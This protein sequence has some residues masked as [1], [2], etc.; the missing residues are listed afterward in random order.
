MPSDTIS[1]SSQVWHVL[2]AAAAVAQLGSNRTNGLSEAE[3]AKRQAHHGPNAIREG[4]RR[5]KL[6]MLLAQFTD[7]LVLLL[8]AA[9]IISGIV[10]DAE[11]TIVIL[12]IVVLNA[13]VGFVQEY[14]ADRAVAALKRMAALNAMVVR[15]GRQQVVPA[16][17]LVPGDI[18][19]LEAGNALPADL[20]I[21][22]VADLKLGEAA[23]T[24]ESMPVEK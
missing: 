6:R 10:G 21:L 1:P 22:E 14:R 4:A 3:V 17:S 16:E 20:R 8:I 2:D 24:G 18:V 7:F 9:A 15:N 5:S 12:G 19:L 11:D 23:L 13:T